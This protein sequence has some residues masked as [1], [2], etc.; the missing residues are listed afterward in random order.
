MGIAALPETVYVRF[1][2]ITRWSGL[3][4][5]TVRKMIKARAWRSIRP[6]GM[7]RNI[8]LRDEVMKAFGS[9]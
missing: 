1:G 7:K 6:K 2:D 5:R 9:H 4:P 3:D 8:Y